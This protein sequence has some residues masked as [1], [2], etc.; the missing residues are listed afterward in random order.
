MEIKNINDEIAISIINEMHK[1]LIG[2]HFPSQNFNHS[3]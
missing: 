3:T 1:F 2:V